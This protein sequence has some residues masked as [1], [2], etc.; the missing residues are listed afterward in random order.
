MYKKK[1]N[2]SRLPII[3]LPLLLILTLGLFTVQAARSFTLSPPILFLD[4][5]E[6]ETISFHSVLP[7]TPIF[8]SEDPSI[9]EAA[10]DGTVTG[11]STG[12]TR[13]FLSLRGRTETVEV[14]VNYGRYLRRQLAPSEERSDYADLDDE[15]Y[16]NFRPVTT[17]GMGKGKLYRSSSPVSPGLNRNKEADA[18]CRKAGIRTILNLANDTD[19]LTSYKS[20][21]KTYYSGQTIRA[22]KHDTNLF[23]KSFRKSLA[24]DLRFLIKNKAPYLIHCTYGRD[25][26]GFTCAVLECLMG[27]SKNEVLKDYM[28]T[29]EN[30][31]HLTEDDPV[32]RDLAKYLMAHDLQKAFGVSSLD[33]VNLSQEAEE[34]LREIGLTKKEI[35]SLKKKLR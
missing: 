9:A 28:V 32:Y 10:P 14:R 33:D 18:A 8:T 12:I 29:Y 25:R 35:K 15:A 11:K 23:S 5:G 19:T 30:Y 1:K 22:K 27:A 16:A 26:T 24:K 7:G 4:T 34:Y 13:I 31:N 17:T 21:K 20:Y 6:E 2:K 3:L